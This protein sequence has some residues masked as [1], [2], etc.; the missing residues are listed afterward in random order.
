MF[1]H[2]KQGAV[3][4]IAGLVPLDAETC[5]RLRSAVEHCL[6]RGQPKL[7]IDLSQTPYID[8]I[9]LETLLDARDLCQSRGG[10]CKLSAPNNLCSDILKATGLQVEFEIVADVVSGAGS[11][12]L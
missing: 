6:T 7:L 12:A 9:G 1:S 2:T 11:F 10:A 3:D 8:S 4:V 5:G